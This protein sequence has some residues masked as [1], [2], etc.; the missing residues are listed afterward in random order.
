[1]TYTSDLVEDFNQVLKYGEQIRFK[2]YNVSY[3][4]GSY[5]DD[6]ITLT[7]SGNDFWCSGLVQSIDTKYGSRDGILLQQGIITIDDKKIYVDNL[8]QTSGLGP[9]KIG[10]TGS[11]TTRQYEILNQG[12]NIDF[13]ING[14]SVYKKIYCRFLTN[15]SFVGE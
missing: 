12:N 4:A 9:I 3:G 1:M 7:Q 14:S 10:T 5:Y 15:G 2:Y 8:T 13:T 6:D 11:P